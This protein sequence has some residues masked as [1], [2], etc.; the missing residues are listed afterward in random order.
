MTDLIS[1]YL[2]PSYVSFIDGDLMKWSFQDGFWS[3]QGRFSTR[4]LRRHLW[5]RM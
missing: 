2:E 3:G 4:E 1:K 5:I